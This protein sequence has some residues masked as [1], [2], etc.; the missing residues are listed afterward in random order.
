MSWPLTLQKREWGRHVQPL[1]K[2]CP[3]SKFIY[4]F[5]FWQIFYFR[6]CSTSEFLNSK[7]VSFILNQPFTFGT[8]EAPY[9]T[10]TLLVV[11]AQSNFKF[12]YNPRLIFSHS[13]RSIG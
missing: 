12:S 7:I 5:L 9:P 13:K 4:D 6:P 8:L 10:G 3:H 2:P 1:M 11:T